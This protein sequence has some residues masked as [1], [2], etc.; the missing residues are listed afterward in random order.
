MIAFLSFSAISKANSFRID[1]ADIQVF[2]K[3]NENIYVEELL[4]Y[5]F[6]G[7]YDGTNRLVSDNTEN[8]VIYF[9]SYEALMDTALK[10]SDTFL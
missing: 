6:D 7:S 4:T 5:S 9:H 2:I 3:P 10:M 1:D 8:E